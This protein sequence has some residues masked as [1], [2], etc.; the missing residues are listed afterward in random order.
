M[1]YDRTTP[2]L[3]LR[4]FIWQNKT[5]LKSVRPG[6]GPGLLAFG[7]HRWF[8][9]SDMPVGAALGARMLI[10]TRH[11]TIETGLSTRDRW[12]S[13]AI[14]CTKLW[15]SRRRNPKIWHIYKLLTDCHNIKSLLFTTGEYVLLWQELPS[16]RASD[17]NYA[18][19]WWISLNLRPTNP[20]RT[21]TWA[22][23][24]SR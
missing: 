14:I 16:N 10:L 9:D 19:H 8:D 22:R 11:H 4:V 15:T 3:N 13:I 20:N 17:Y 21:P 24:R 12:S 1:S 18:C 5:N 23:N 7:A 2:N 6:S